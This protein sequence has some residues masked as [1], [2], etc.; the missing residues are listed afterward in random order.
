MVDAV[1]K[2]VAGF[3]DDGYITASFDSAVNHNDTTIAFIEKGRQYKWVDLGRGNLDKNL[4]K[5]VN[6]R[7]KDFVARPFSIKQYSKLRNEI[8]DISE[9]S[10]FPFASVNLD[11][12]E[13]Q[14][15]GIKAE[16]HY[17]PGPPIKFDSLTIVGSSKLNPVFIER[18]F[19]I[20]RN[21]VFDRSKIKDADRF[22]SQFPSI[23]VVRESNII[24][25][26]YKA[27]P[28][29]FLNHNPANIIDGIVGF[30]PNE[31]K[32]GKLLL[33]GQF[34]LNLYN[35]GGAGKDL[36]I[37]WNKLKPLS[38]LLNL[39]FTNYNLLKSGLDIEGKFNLLKEDTTFLNLNARLNI[40]KYLRNNFGRV[41]FYTDYKNS[42]ISSSGSKTAQ[43]ENPA[44]A[45]YDIVSYG[46]GYQ[47]QNLDDILNPRKGWK[48]QIESLVGNKNIRRNSSLDSAV[49]QNIA[50][51]SVQA[52]ISS[53]LSIHQSVSRKSGVFLKLTGGLINNKNLFLSDLFRL[54]GLR[55]LRGFNENYF[56]ASSFAI[57]N[58]EYRYFYEED[59]YF[60]LF[61]DQGYLVSQYGKN[62]RTDLPLGLGSGLNLKTAVGVLQIY[63]SLGQSR[64]Q[65]LSFNYSKVHF[66]I[67]NRF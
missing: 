32:Q 11:S 38:Q 37:E 34:V 44:L 2:T 63:Y 3:V 52:T 59:S 64:D 55:S 51:K 57:S 45:D 56:F 25:S 6:F 60:V 1:Q 61:Y 58:I 41:N 31:Q 67:V 5:Q 39:Q 4:L 53:A 54:G 23:K 26:N 15:G 66:G 16:L 13:I 28:V 7:R 19:R 65:K 50:E 22:L 33:T 29:L 24:Y 49:Y 12:I 43:L 20:G 21:E 36:L 10:G 18:Y 17:N 42:R 30:L 48:F 27:Y 46:L 40:S 62:N 14:E 9:N 8:L 35:I 47:W